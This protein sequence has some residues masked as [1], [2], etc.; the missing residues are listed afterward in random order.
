MSKLIIIRTLW[1]VEPQD[2]V[3]QSAQSAVFCRVLNTSH[4][5]LT[6]ITL[7]YR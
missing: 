1:L 6:S 5:S 4:N 7:L 2:I 3:P